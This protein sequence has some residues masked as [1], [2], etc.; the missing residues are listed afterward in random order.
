MCIMKQILIQYGSD[1]ELD[2]RLGEVRKEF[3]AGG[4][5]HILFHIY[6]GILDEELLT[7]IA[8]KIVGDFPETH[9]VGTVSAGEIMEARLM[10]RGI[11]ISAMLFVSTEVRE[12]R[13]EDVKGRESEVGRII[14]ET[15]TAT[16]DLKAIELLMP[17]TELNTRLILEEISRCDDSIKVFGGYA[18]G[19]DMNIGEHY[20]FDEKGLSDNAVFALGYIGKDFHID[21]DKSVG[22]QTL[23]HHFE[24]TKADE[25]RLIEINNR[26]AVEIYEKY[27]R[28]NRNENFAENTFE[29]PLIVKVGG[30]ELLRHTITVEKDGTL[31]LAGY[32]TEGMYIYLCYGNPS[33]IVEQVNKRL[34]RVRQF[35]PEAILLY[36]CSVRKSFWEKY[37]D[38]EMEPFQ[39]LAETA[40]FHTWGEV[41]RN[42]LTNDVLEYN[43][44]L[45][46]IAMREGDAPEGELPEVKINDSVLEG[47]ASLIKRL[48]QLVSATTVELQNTYRSLEELNKKLVKLSN[49]DALTG[50]Y[51]RRRF[52]EIADEGLDTIAS[53]GRIASMIML[54]LDHFKLVNDNYGHAIGDSVLIEFADILK[55]TVKSVEGAAVGRWG[56]EEFLIYLPDVDKTGAAEYAERIRKEVE[57]H[58]FAGVKRT[59]TT[60]LGVITTDGKQDKHEMFINVD[61]SLY[62]AKKRGRNCFVQYAQ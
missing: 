29:F 30:D 39:E 34:D 23:G 4:Y 52:E 25:N 35:R 17:G 9:V 36:S 47:Q 5:K 22:W 40:G 12:L 13:I 38:M 44:T 61:N 51:N 2:I 37:V 26:P 45:L 3:E 58:I 53:E 48:T 28:I 27:L 49:H 60:S 6:S 31:D 14:A 18:G 1:E 55:E 54:D 33:L 8:G 21:V 59:I 56:G 57:S 43:I 32:V 10:D 15:S 19:H 11:L 20:I 46:S 41:K 42:P 62:E 24:V 16:E 7:C 50:L